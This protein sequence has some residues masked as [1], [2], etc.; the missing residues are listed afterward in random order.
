MS[1]MPSRGKF[2]VRLN[3]GT[4]QTISP[5]QSYTIPPGHDAW[6]VG[7]V[8]FVGIEVIGAE[9]YATPQT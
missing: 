6:V 2:A 9:Q 1:G 3:D 4:L 8:P 5:G 7:S